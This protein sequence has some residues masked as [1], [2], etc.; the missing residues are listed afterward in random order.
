V[1][2]DPA[3][4]ALPTAPSAVERSLEIWRQATIV[5]HEWFGVAV[6]TTP[7]DRPRVEAAVGTVYAQ[8]LRPRPAFVWADS[9]DAAL[10]LLPP[11]LPTL[12][13]LYDRIT[14]PRVAGPPPLASDLAAALS[15]LR[16]RLDEGLLPGDSPP[17]QKPAEKERKFLAPEQAI[18]AGVPVRK[19]LREVI[20]EGL[21]TRIAQGVHRPIR[22]ALGKPEHLPVCWYG[23]QDAG[24][25]GY[26]DLLRRLGL[27]RYGAA[28]SERLEL[29]AD[30]ARHGGWWWP[31]E[32]VCVLVDRPLSLSLSPFSVRYPDGWTC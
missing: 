2:R 23:Q 24:W 22:E 21:Q 3:S 15:G 14:L 19:L 29:W 27:A 10:R 25:I 1:T 11:G 28:E 9:P 26:Y 17:R 16:S 20:R 5:E 12:G 30:L 18:R 31:G 13:D 32:D 4:P 8:L 6:S 7:A